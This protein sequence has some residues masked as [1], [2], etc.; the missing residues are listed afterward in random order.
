MVTGG[1]PASGF[2]T[3]LA[4]PNCACPVYGAQTSVRAELAALV[5]ALEGDPRPLSVRSDCR[6]VVDGYRDRDRHRARAWLK[7]PLDA[8]PIPHADLWRRVDRAARC[9]TAAGV[10]TEVRW[11]KGHPLEGHVKE[12]VTT[13]LD[14]FGKSQVDMLATLALQRAAAEGRASRPPPRRPPRAP[15]P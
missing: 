2:S 1:W 14:A 3:A 4:T 11:C 9:R 13:L 8:V 12:G 15:R 6:V 7:R 5:H 10:V